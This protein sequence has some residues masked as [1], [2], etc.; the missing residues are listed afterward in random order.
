MNHN[1]LSLINKCRKCEKQITKD[2]DLLVTVH[3]LKEALI[4]SKTL[5]TVTI[6]KLNTCKNLTGILTDPTDKLTETLIPLT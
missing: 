6:R 2:N 4:G 1:L 5:T 3:F